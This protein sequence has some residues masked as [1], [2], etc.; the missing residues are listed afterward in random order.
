MKPL[1]TVLLPVYNG[2]EYVKEA[3]D[4]ILNQTFTDF[5]LLI[6]D[7]GSTDNSVEIVEAYMDNR[8]RL[9]KNEKNLGLTPTFNKGVD[10]IDTKYTA[11]MD[12][13]DISNPTRFEKQVAYLEAHPNV[14]MVDALN[15]FIDK[16]GKIMDRVFNGIHTEKEL[17]DSLPNDNLISHPTMMIRTDIYKKYKYRLIQ[18]EDYDLWLRLANDGHVIHRINEVL[19]KYRIHGNSYTDSGKKKS[20]GT[21]RQAIT[22]RSYL[23]YIPFKDRFTWFNIRVFYYMLKQYIIGYVKYL[24]GYNKLR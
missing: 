20:S 13:D 10:M 3:I 18:F 8:I 9:V 7:D 2:A 6:I 5:E 4:S 21:L 11:R 17:R 1:V 23:N 14:A 24:I 15:V 22:K 12:A 16:D 19:L